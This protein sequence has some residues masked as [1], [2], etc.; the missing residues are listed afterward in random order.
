MDI[1]RQHHV[2]ELL[3]EHG[4]REEGDRPQSLLAGIDK[5]VP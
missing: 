5:I 3:G 1:R 4:R 2:V